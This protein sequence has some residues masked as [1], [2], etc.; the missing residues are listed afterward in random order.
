MSWNISSLLRS[1][2]TTAV[3][4]VVV[5]IIEIFLPAVTYPLVIDRSP[6]RARCPSHPDPTGN[7]S[8]GQNVTDSQLRSTKPYKIYIK[9]FGFQS[10][11]PDGYKP[12]QGDYPGEFI[13]RAK[14]AIGDAQEIRAPEKGNYGSASVY[15]A[16]TDEQ[17]QKLERAKAQPQFKDFIGDVEQW[18]PNMKE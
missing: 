10:E 1:L 3:S 2:R 17:R 5:T 11:I 7:Y 16:L 18:D 13:K 9:Y 6:Q 8:T 4:R 15:Y 14:Q 12:G